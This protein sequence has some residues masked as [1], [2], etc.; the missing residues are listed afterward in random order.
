MSPLQ[1]FYPLNIL[2]SLGALD[3]FF[4]RRRGEHHLERESDHN[5]QR[6]DLNRRG[7]HFKGTEGGGGR[8]D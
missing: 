6:Q 7:G 1:Y 2:P 8:E 4:V 3:L 5:D